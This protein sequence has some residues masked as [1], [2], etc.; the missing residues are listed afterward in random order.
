MAEIEPARG[1]SPGNDTPPAENQLTT[2]QLADLQS[3]A[4]QQAYRRAYLEQLRRQSCPGCGDEGPLS[5]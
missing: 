1:Q 4:T 3:P 2:E 5:F